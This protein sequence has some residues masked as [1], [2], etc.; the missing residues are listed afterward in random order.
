MTGPDGVGAA[1]P[2]VR[3]VARRLTVPDRA[4]REDLAEFVGRAVRLDGGVVVRLRSR[5]GAD[6]DAD[7][8]EAALQQ[9]A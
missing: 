1:V 2:G 4:Q 9:G 3:P 6:G 8:V 5:P 7:A